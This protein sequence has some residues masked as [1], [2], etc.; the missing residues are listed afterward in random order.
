M[1]ARRAAAHRA[2]S[3]HR[4]GRPAAVRRGRPYARPTASTAGRSPHR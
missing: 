4:R 1:P 3:S 2:V